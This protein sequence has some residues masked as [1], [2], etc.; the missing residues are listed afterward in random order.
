MRIIK[1]CRD[2]SSEE[3]CPV[4][5]LVVKLSQRRIVGLKKFGTA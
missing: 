2:N 3:V 1:E 4:P 5:L